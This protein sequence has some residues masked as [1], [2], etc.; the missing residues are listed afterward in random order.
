MEDKF[1]R[2]LLERLG[3]AEKETGIPEPR[4]AEQV[5]TQ[6]GVKAVGEYLRRGRLTRQFS[7]LKEQG[8]LELTPE[9]LVIQGKYGALFSDE[10]V[11]ICLDRLLEAGFFRRS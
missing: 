5:R 2:E 4:L 9:S 1:T 10:Q 11:N 6:G 8:K 3:Q 7:A